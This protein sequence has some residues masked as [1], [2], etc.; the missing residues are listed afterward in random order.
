ML[1]LPSI[2]VTLRLI[3]GEAKLAQSLLQARLSA[4][5]QETEG[6]CP[7]SAEALHVAL[8]VALRIL[9]VPVVAVVLIQRVHCLITG[10]LQFLGAAVA[11]RL[12]RVDGLRHNTLLHSRVEAPTWIRTT[13]FLERPVEVAGRELL[14]CNP[15][16]HTPSLLRLTLVAAVVQRARVQGATPFTNNQIT[17]GL[18]RNALEELGRVTIVYVQSPGMVLCRSAVVFLGKAAV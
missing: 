2:L 13:L 11:T 5:L 3:R 18:V 12:Q 4:L 14:E 6:V 9:R 7:G 10:L 16:R 15:L 1:K 8:V 17:T